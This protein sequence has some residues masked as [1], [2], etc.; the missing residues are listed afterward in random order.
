[1]AH[2][3]TSGFENFFVIQGLVEDSGGHVGYT[4]DR[5]N[6][7]P[8]VARGDGFRRRGHSYKVRANRAQV[9]NLGWCFVTWTEKRYVHAFARW[10]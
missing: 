10:D 5:Q 1:M 2:D 6:I 8:H 9:A 3:A 4:G 7:H